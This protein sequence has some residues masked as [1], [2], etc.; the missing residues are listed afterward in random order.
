MLPEVLLKA[1]TELGVCEFCTRYFGQ[2]F[3]FSW[4]EAASPPL[5]LEEIIEKETINLSYFAPV[6]CPN[7]LGLA[8]MA[9]ND[10]FLHWV[11]QK[12]RRSGYEFADFNFNFKL[13]LSLKFRQR[14]VT[15]H[16]LQVWEETA[17]KNVPFPVF[18]FD[19]KL[20]I[21]NALNH[22]VGDKLGVPPSPA[23]E[24]IINLEFRNVPDEEE[25]VS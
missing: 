13:P 16:L 19:L 7:C 22:A 23:E 8:Q 4:P 20:S 1:L 15:N 6:L 5:N 14:F 12:T 24:F 25:L 2:Q 18:D 17:G 3:K 10:A 11:V 21:K 9:N